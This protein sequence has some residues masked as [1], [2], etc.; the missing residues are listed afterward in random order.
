MAAI[1]DFGMIL[2]IFDL[3]I[4]QV[5][6]QFAFGSVEEVQNRFLRINFRSEQF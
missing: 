2:A 6:S 1:L 4:T 3:Q 5:S